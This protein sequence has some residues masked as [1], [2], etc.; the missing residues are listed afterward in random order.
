MAATSTAQT[1][2]HLP[3]TPDGLSAFERGIVFA[4]GAFIVA[5]LTSSVLLSMDLR[6]RAVV[7]ATQQLRNLSLVLSQE[8]DRALQ[9]VE[10]VQQGVIDKMRDSGITTVEAFR[11]QMSDRDAHE[12]LRDRVTGLSYAD[13]IMLVTH[14]GRV[15]NSSRAWP[16]D[17]AA[18][19]AE[20]SYYTALAAD[21][22]LDHFLTAPIADRRANSAMV[23]LARRFTAPDG[24]LIGFVLGAVRLQSIE[25]FLARVDIGAGGSIALLCDDGTLLARS[26]R[27]GARV[28]TKFAWA[29]SAAIHFRREGQPPV[30]KRSVIDGQERLFWGAPLPHFPAFIAVSYRI[31]RVDAAWWPEVAVICGG[32]LLMSMAAAV[33]AWLSLRQ[34]RTQHRFARQASHAARHDIL[35]GLPNRLMFHEEAAQALNA[36]AAQPVAVILF[37]LDAFKLINDVYGHSAGDS[38]LRIVAER[39]QYVLPDK[40]LASRLGGDEFAILHPVSAWPSQAEA[41][42]ETLQAAMQRPIEL[43]NVPIS[44][45]A[46]IGI[47]C[48]PYDGKD[49][50]TVL[51]G[52]DLALYAAKD[53]GAGNFRIF[54]RMM[55]DH[56]AARRQLDLGLR[57]ALRERRFVLY[58]QP[59]ISGLDGS[60]I[61]FEALLRWFDP[62]RG[63]I[64]P[65]DFI[66]VAEETG[67]IVEL[68]GWVLEQA[69]R[70]AMGWPLPLRVSVNV[71]ARQFHAGD[72]YARVEDALRQS[73]LPPQRLELE[74]TES[75]LLQET[76]ALRQ[77]FEAL[78]ALGVAVALD[79]F[80]IGYSSLAYLR[81]FPVDRVKIDRSFVKDMHAD[82]DDARI[83]S[84]LIV[85]SHI[86]GMEVTAEGVETEEQQQLLQRAGCDALQGYLISRPLAAAVVPIWLRRQPRG[87]PHA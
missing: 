32:G 8:T 73:G 54:D 20:T 52:A 38:L 15:V 28:G 29:K 10:T 67:L 19:I 57:A 42:A 70:E 77:T 60:T 58:F 17:D 83:V 5:V 71:S 76:P 16:A 49:I 56:V 25:D 35:T 69:C 55:A 18:S 82:N 79:D 85:L 31:E 66:P 46:S 12:L 34:L 23:F 63:M 84:S 74:I 9:A 86:L 51:R 48:A 24:K 64:S 2:A 41:L 72:L 65:A 6:D 13:A 50:D 22:R 68:G 14:D 81:R 75:V 37:D 40:R 78:Q 61:G 44:V 45:S 26:P 43:G 53:Q 21:P 3:R 11:K 1:T 30:E 87:A 7:S 47:A 4:A 36:S 27:A 33:C 59:V 39:L 80:G 62:E